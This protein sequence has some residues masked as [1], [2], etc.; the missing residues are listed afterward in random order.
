MIKKGFVFILTSICFS[1]FGQN[2]PDEFLDHQ[3]QIDSLY[4]LLKYD[5]ALQIAFQNLEIAKTES[6]NL[7]LGLAQS[8]IS[9]LYFRKGNYDSTTY[10]SKQ[11]MVLGSENKLPE[12]MISALH[13]QGNVHYSKFEDNDAI[14]HY[15]KIDSISKQYSEKNSTV[16]NALYNLGNVLLRSYSA[17]DTSYIGISKNYYQNGIKIASEIA[18]PDDEHYGYVLLGGVYALRKEYEKASSYYRKSLSYFENIGFTKRVANIYW[19]LGIL[20]TDL[21]NY[22]KAEFYYKKRLD[23]LTQTGDPHEIA[24]A[25]RVYAGFLYRVERYREVIPYLEKAY[26]HFKTS[27]EGHSGIMLGITNI[28][29]E[30]YKETGDFERAADFYSETL[31]HQDSLEARSQKDLALDLEAKYQSQKKEQEIALLKS[32]SELAEERKKNQ[33][34]ILLG[35]IVLISL[36]ALSLFLLY[37]NR[38]K[39]NKRLLELDTAK[40]NFFAN[41]SHELRT[42]LSLIQGPVDQ[43]LEKT[44]LSTQDRQNLTIAKNNTER[45][46]TLVDQLLDLSKLESNFYKLQVCQG[47]LS[48]FLKSIAESFEFKARTKSQLL[49]IKISVDEHLYWYD[50]DV[51]QK[52]IVNLLGNALKYSPGKAHI[53][54]RANIRDSNLLLSVK[55]TGISLS[56]E[57][58]NNIFD[59]FHRSHEN[60]TGTGIGLALTKELVELHKGHIH[61][62][63]D[64]NS[65][66]FTIEVP[67][68]KNAFSKEE[69][70]TYPKPTVPAPHQKSVIIPTN[71]TATKEG[72]ETM[73]IVLIVDDNEDICTYISSILWNKYNVITAKNGNIGFQKALKQVPDLIITDLMMPKDNGLILTENCKTHDAT[74]HIPIVMLTAKTGEENRLQGLETGAD[75]YLTKPFNNKILRQT[76][77]NLLESRKK[78]QKRFSQEVILTPKDVSIGSYDQRFLESLQ[79]ILDNQL[80]S[81]DFNTEAFAN[82]LGMSRMQLHR[83]LKALTGQTATEFIRGQRLKLAAKLLKESDVNIS[84]IGYQVGFN[85]HSY[86][87]K[88]FRETYGL[89]PSEFSRNQI[90]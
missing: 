61:V 28:L 60:E 19:S 42:P 14:D 41:I 86:F 11:A 52:I 10:Y 65:V 24:N 13:A 21:N 56:K 89:S 54:F 63:S 27:D 23:L 50:E 4:K 47:L 83:K 16:V 70:T 29:A 7:L 18:S 20:E 59:R 66:F 8:R 58:L 34:H 75:A 37:R 46:T 80:V 22:E 82:A 17:E 3:T 39:T 51:L 43:Q 12:V 45:L 77:E 30:S 81:S 67:V 48:F 79:H 64:S 36:V 69:K 33:Q 53:D 15:Q 5:D 35:G 31:V 72:E 87:T 49:N 71:E 76:V 32:Q 1:S 85:D 90:S 68:H 73:D 38:Q 84:E 40:S 6:S 26:E 88:C 78:L 55:N 62:N 57:K 44:G 9:H 2:I 25:N 74:S